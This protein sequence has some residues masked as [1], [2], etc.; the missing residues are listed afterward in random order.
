MRA[1]VHLAK[2]AD[3]GLAYADL[4]QVD[5]EVV[6]ICQQRI[7]LSLAYVVA[8]LRVAHQRTDMLDIRVGAE[9]ELAAIIVHAFQIAQP[10]GQYQRNVNQLGGTVCGQHGVIVSVQ[11][12]AEARRNLTRGIGCGTLRGILQERV[13]ITFAENLV[14]ECLR[15][16]NARVGYH[17]HCLLLAQARDEVDQLGVL[18]LVADAGVAE[19]AAE[20]AEGGIH[21]VHAG[22]YLHHRGLLNDVAA[23]DDNAALLESR[24]TVRECVLD[25]QVVRTFGVDVNSRVRALFGYE[26]LCVLQTVSRQLVCD[27]VIRM[28]GNLINHGQREG[29]LLEQEVILILGDEAATLPYACHV[30]DSTL[31]TGAVIRAVI[32]RNECQ[33]RQTGAAALEAQCGQLAEEGLAAFRTV[34]AVVLVVRQ[35]LTGVILDDIALLGQRKADHLQARRQENVLQ[36]QHVLAQLEAFGNGR[37]HFLVDR[38]VGIQGD[39]QRQM[40]A[41]AVA[42]VD[43]LLIVAVAAD[44]AGVGQTGGQQ[45]LRQYSREGAEQVAG[46]EM[47][48]SRCLVGVFAHGVNVVL[49]QTITLPCHVMFNTLFCKFHK[50]VTPFQRTDCTV[51]LQSYIV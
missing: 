33:R 30:T 21:R 49:R 31:Q 50:E 47:Q 14:Q 12:S 18:H 8:Q 48:P 26:R 4:K 19:H 44:N 10:A 9:G 6:A 27:A 20:Y 17:R 38:A 39:N 40:I 35:E 25:E 45:A 3:N 22:A 46:A 13:R 16:D 36:A 11:R 28:R 37:N 43:Q 34:L 29:I 7:Q 2:H 41:G 51:L 23:G 32:Q 15:V 5:T 24:M 1:A 42:A